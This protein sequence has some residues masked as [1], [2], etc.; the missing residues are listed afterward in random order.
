MKNQVKKF[1]QNLGGTT[2]YSGKTKTMYC[3]E[4]LHDTILQT[5]GYGLP[6][7]LGTL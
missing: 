3:N 4:V 2:K 5:F 1:V 7:T 6:F